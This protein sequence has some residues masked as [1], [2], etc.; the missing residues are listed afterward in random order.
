MNGWEE[1]KAV[2]HYLSCRPARS[3]LLSFVSLLAV[4][5]FLVGIRLL[6]K[7]KR[8][9]KFLAPS[10]TEHTSIKSTRSKERNRDHLKD[11]AKRTYTSLDALSSDLSSAF[12]L[13]FS[14]AFSAGFSASFSASFLASELFCSSCNSS[15]SLAH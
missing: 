8:V 6:A 14:S 2:V 1:G 3:N 7:R 5:F 4:R 9:S 15:L 11:G 10:E 13:A 12:S